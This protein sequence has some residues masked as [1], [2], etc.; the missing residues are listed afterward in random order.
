[1]VR[2]VLRDLKAKGSVAV[3]GRGPGARWTRRGNASQKG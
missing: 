2:R 1:M 3:S